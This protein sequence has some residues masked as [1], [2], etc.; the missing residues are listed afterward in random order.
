MSGEDPAFDES[1]FPAADLDGAGFVTEPDLAG[2]VPP[3]IAA[4]QNGHSTA[5]SSSTD[6][7]HAGHV[8][9][10]MLPRT[11]FGRDDFQLQNTTLREK[12]PAAVDGGD[13]EDGGWRIEDGE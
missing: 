5:S 4:P 11:L 10:S 8:G 13:M 7:L 2:A 1:G 9:R 12:T 3:F 6:C